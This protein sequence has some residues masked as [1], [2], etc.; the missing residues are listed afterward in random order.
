MKTSVNSMNLKAIARYALG[1]IL[2]E[3]RESLTICPSWFSKKSI[4]LESK[5][6]ATN[7]KERLTVAQA[8]KDPFF[9]KSAH[10]T[11]YF[12]KVE[13][14]YETAGFI[15][16]YLIEP[17]KEKQTNTSKKEYDAFHMLR[18]QQLPV[19]FSRKDLS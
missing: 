1:K 18:Q 19:N 9:G 6:K 17:L 15:D 2:E 12:K 14:L 3:M 16:H 5:L 13:S 4:A 7:P 10:A 8:I 11:T